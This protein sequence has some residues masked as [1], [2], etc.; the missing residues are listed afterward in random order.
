MDNCIGVVPGFTPAAWQTLRVHQA[1]RAT[2]SKIVDR[3]HQGNA[4]SLRREMYGR[5]QGRVWV[6]KVN[7]VGPEPVYQCLDLPSMVR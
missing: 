7:D 3:H 5:A 2:K 1:I 6:V 4:L